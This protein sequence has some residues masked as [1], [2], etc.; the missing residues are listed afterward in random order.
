LDPANSVRYV[1]A[2]VLKATFDP[3]WHVIV[4]GKAVV[5]YMVVPGFVAITVGPGHHTVVFQYIAYSHYPLL[6]GIGAMT[7]LILAF[8]PWL[9]RTR[10]RRV[11]GPLV[12]RLKRTRT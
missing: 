3:R 6:L 1:D 8:G 4:D 12:G 11:W 7:L 9:W 2:V 5:P 10:G